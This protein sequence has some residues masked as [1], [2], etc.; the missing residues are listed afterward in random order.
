MNNHISTS[1]LTKGIYCSFPI[2][3][4]ILINISYHIKYSN[5][6]KKNGYGYDNLVRDLSIHDPSVV[7][8]YVNWWKKT[9][10]YNHIT[11]EFINKEIKTEMVTKFVNDILL[12]VKLIK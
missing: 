1:I 2:C 7:T 6:L 4:G 10:K 9:N 8:V 12:E 11:V 3:K 5:G